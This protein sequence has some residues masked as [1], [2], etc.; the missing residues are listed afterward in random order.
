MTVAQRHPQIRLPYMQHLQNSMVLGINALMLVQRAQ[1]AWRLGVMA[2]K[3]GWGGMRG[4]RVEGE[5]EIP[6]RKGLWKMTAA[7]CQISRRRRGEEEEEEEDEEEEAEEEK[8]LW[9][10]RSGFPN[11]SSPLLQIFS[12]KKM[13]LEA[14]T[15]A[16]PP[17]TP[18][19]LW[20]RRRWSKG[21][22]H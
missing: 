16:L 18:A 4:E 13:S 11:M 5:R 7:A 6:R 22:R 17:H 10:P 1:G 3:S 19:R 14:N 9:L 21:I 15:Q 8:E 12:S 2:G 20:Q